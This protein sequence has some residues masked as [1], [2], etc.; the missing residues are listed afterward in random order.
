MKKYLLTVMLITGVIS[1]TN[2]EFNTIKRDA[3]GNI[4]DSGQVISNEKVIIST[5]YGT[6]K[7]QAL[8]NAFK[9]AIEQYIG[10]FVDSETMIK[11]GKLIKDNILTSSNGF[12]KKYDELSI[13]KADGLIEMKIK[14]VVK[15]QKIFTQIKKL[16]IS[17]IYIDNTKDI[18]PRIRTKR[19]SKEDALKILKK[20]FENLFSTSSIQDML[21]IKIL[22][23]KVEEDKVKDDTVPIRI[24]YELSINYENYIQKMKKLEQL[25]ENIG[26]TLHKRAYIY[27]VNKQKS[28]YRSYPKYFRP[29]NFNYSYNQTVKKLAKKYTIFGIVKKYGQGYKLDIWCFP[30]NWK[31]IYF[32]KSLDIKELLRG[33]LEIKTKDNEVLLAEELE[34]IARVSFIGSMRFDYPSYSQ[35]RLYSGIKVISPTFNT[36]VTKVK[37]QIIVYINLNAVSKIKKVV[38]ELEEK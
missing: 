22:S 13:D 32:G 2:F 3:E 14:A 24:E 20:Y 7:E 38:L 9:S 10:V 1:A 18:Y 36:D 19:K 15:S 35:Y 5:G 17:T 37:K 30:K 8:K 4:K 11:N 12:I 29:V 26:G 16:K 6:T 23:A 27:K 33:V 21:N 34:E 25:F 28:I 31:N